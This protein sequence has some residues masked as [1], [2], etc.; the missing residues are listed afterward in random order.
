MIS[1]KLKLNN[2]QY[3]NGPVGQSLDPR[4]A[5]AGAH[6]RERENYP[7]VAWKTRPALVNEQVSRDL[8]RADSHPLLRK[9]GYARLG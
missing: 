6:A 9:I 1:R 8:I 2:R 7:P 5:G 3:F 4:L